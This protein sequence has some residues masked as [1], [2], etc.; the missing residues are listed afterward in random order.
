MIDIINNNESYIKKTFYES[1]KHISVFA[2]DFMPILKSYNGFGNK[3]LFLCSVLLY[4]GTRYRQC[5]SS[6]YDE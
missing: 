5:A 2:F 1:K 4:Y 6:V 3:C